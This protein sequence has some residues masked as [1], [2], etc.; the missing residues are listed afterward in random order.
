MPSIK[1]RW[2]PACAGRTCI[3]QSRVLCWPVHSFCYGDLRPWKR[4][5]EKRAIH[6]RTNHQNASHK[7]D[8]C[9]FGSNG[10]RCASGSA[11][12]AGRFDHDGIC[13]NRA[14]TVD[15]F[16]SVSAV[17]LRLPHPGNVRLCAALNLPRP[18]AT[19]CRTP[20]VNTNQSG[21]RHQD[22]TIMPCRAAN[23]L[24][25]HSASPMIPAPCRT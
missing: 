12:N 19:D 5:T 6:N 15:A 17:C 3:I 14:N 1:R 10:N 9:A 18:G 21:A 2:M 11:C 22:E 8:S 24:T 4:T 23:R 20:D 7:W 13:P 25:P 16:D